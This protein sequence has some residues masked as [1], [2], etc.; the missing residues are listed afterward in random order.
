MSEKTY[1]TAEVCEMFNISKSTLFRWEREGI[2][3]SIPRDIGGQRKYGQASLRLISERQ[4]EK[5]GRRFEQ[6]AEDGDEDSYWEI[7]EALALNKFLEG[8]P[9]GL[10]ELAEHPRVSSQTQLQLLKIAL[11]QYQPGDAVF[12]EIIK[13]VYEQSSPAIQ[14]LNDR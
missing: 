10:L 3:P 2:L 7:S 4:K 9:T 6:I 12:H 14:S 1:T 13:I 11:E 8:D 5:L